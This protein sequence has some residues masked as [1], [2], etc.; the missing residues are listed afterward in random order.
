MTRASAPDRRED[1]R[2]GWRSAVRTSRW[3]VDGVPDL[4]RLDPGPA[5]VE[6]VDRRVLVVGE[7]PGPGLTS[8][9]GRDDRGRRG[10]RRTGTAQ[11]R[12]CSTAGPGRIDASPGSKSRSKSRQVQVAP[13]A[14]PRRGFPARTDLAD[15]ML[16]G[17][18]A[19]PVAHRPA[20]GKCP[21]PRTTSGGPQA[22]SA[23][24]RR[25]ETSAGP[26]GR[27][28]SVV[29]PCKPGSSRSPPRASRPR[30]TPR[31]SRPGSHHRGS[32]S[33]RVRPWRGHSR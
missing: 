6:V 7:Q 22:S 21:A 8:E 30:G 28:S 1:F 14:E 3:A 4:Y 9:V 26:R 18:A 33:A 31:P 24:R 16:G 5:P 23:R 29:A 11:G 15:K 12:R 32:R 10:R 19:H 27:R 2:Y 25:V 20:G 13:A 17:I